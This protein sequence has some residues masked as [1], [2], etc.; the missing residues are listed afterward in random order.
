[1]LQQ[2]VLSYIAGG[3]PQGDSIIVDNSG[4]LDANS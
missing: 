4:T 1:M 2:T 3:W